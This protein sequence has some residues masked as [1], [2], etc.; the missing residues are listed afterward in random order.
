MAGFICI[1]T[2]VIFTFL[3][4]GDNQYTS[5]QTDGFSGTEERGTIIYTKYYD[6]M[7]P[8]DRKEILEYFLKIAK[9]QSQY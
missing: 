9:L 5:I 8:V 1:G 2:K 6:F 7:K 4:I 3:E